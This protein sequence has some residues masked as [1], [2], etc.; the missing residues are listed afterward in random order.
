MVSRYRRGA[1]G[2]EKYVPTFGAYATSKVGGTVAVGDLV[3]VTYK[4]NN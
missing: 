4:R 1:Y 3:T 2:R